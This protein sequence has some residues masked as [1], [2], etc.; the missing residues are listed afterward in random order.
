MLVAHDSCFYIK[1]GSYWMASVPVT[2]AYML[3]VGNITIFVGLTDAIKNF[4]DSAQNM[5]MTLLLTQAEYGK[6][7]LATFPLSGG[8][9]IKGAI[10]NA[11]ES[12]ALADDADSTD[13]PSGNGSIIA[14]SFEDLSEPLSYL[15][16]ESE[17]GIW[18]E[19]RAVLMACSDPPLPPP[20]PFST[21]I[22]ADLPLVEV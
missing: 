7:Q 16:T 22:R 4:D 12:D 18:E 3:P 10:D 1:P 5:R 21:L 14:T 20:D 13:P 11:V 8:G 9:S 15:E 6:A 17:D 2:R 19:P